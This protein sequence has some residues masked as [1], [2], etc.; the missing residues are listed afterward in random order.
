MKLPKSIYQKKYEANNRGMRDILMAQDNNSNME[1]EKY[2]ADEM[3]MNYET[4]VIKKIMNEKSD[5]AP[6][7]LENPWSEWASV[8]NENS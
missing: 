3:Q 1:K 4:A 7:L 8:N 5:P 6:V 2:D